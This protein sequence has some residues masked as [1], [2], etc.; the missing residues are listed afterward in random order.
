MR[1]PRAQKLLRV[2]AL[3][4]ECHENVQKREAARAAS[5]R[6]RQR[7]IPVWL[8]PRDAQGMCGAQLGRAV[9]C[10]TFASQLPVRNEDINGA[11]RG[12]QRR[13][14]GTRGRTKLPVETVSF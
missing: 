3:Q 2:I 1:E 12:D 8:A 6:S 9:A 10:T 5:G 4:G 11:G 14:V 13:T 7:F